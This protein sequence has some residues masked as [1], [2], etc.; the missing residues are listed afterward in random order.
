MA[1][2]FRI[3][4]RSIKV[5]LPSFPSSRGLDEPEQLVGSVQGKDASAPEERFAKALD[6]AGIQ[7]IFRYT[8]GAPKGL[9]GW[10]EVDFIMV[11][12]GLVYAVEV[13]TAFTHRNKQQSDVLHDAIILN[14]RNVRE[15]GDIYPQVQ[16]VSGD[17]DLADQDKADQYVKTRY[18]RSGASTVGRANEYEAPNPPITTTTSGSKINKSTPGSSNSQKKQKNKA[19]EK[20]EKQKKRELENQKK[21][22]KLE[23]KKKNKKKKGL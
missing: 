1:F 14:D 12:N 7:Y 5:D 18:K 23:N 11:A 15:M 4:K 2:K 22:K 9:P 10:K 19:K 21:K 16:H 20:L 17:S 13:D 3:T 8:V 6:K